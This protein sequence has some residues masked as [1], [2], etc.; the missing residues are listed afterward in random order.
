[1]HYYLTR[2]EL[3]RDVMWTCPWD[4]KDKRLYSSRASARRHFVWGCVIAR[5]Y[6]YA[7]AVVLACV[8]PV[9]LAALAGACLP[10]LLYKQVGHPGEQIWWSRAYLTLEATVIV[11]LALVLRDH[12]AALAI[13]VGAMLGV[14]WLMA[15]DVALKWH[16][17][18]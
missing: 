1:M 5:V 3:E 7:G 6:V 16:H 11:V 2:V 12:R 4:V 15:A 17:Y 9:A 14:H 10:W 13:A 8:E 18:H